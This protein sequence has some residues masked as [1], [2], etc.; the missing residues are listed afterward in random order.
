MK[1]PAVARELGFL[2]VEALHRYRCAKRVRISLR[3]LQRT[4][5]IASVGGD[6]R[7]PEALTLLS[8]FGVTAAAERRRTKRAEVMHLVSVAAKHGVSSDCVSYQRSVAR[9]DRGCKHDWVGCE[10][11]RMSSPLSEWG[12]FGG[13]WMCPGCGGASSVDGLRWVCGCPPCAVTREVVR[14]RATTGPL[15]PPPAVSAT[16]PPLAVSI[17]NG[18]VFVA[19]LLELPTSL[20]RAR[21]RSA[22]GGKRKDEGQRDRDGYEVEYLEREVAVLRRR[23]LNALRALGAP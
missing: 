7:A 14:R 11:C 8:A 17:A 2:S 12:E 22:R 21:L 4:L 16:L 18:N 15:K 3:V 9:G 5:A 10:T 23:Y 6:S 13:E 1:L 20:W 19:Q